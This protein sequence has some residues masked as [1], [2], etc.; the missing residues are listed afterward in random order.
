VPYNLQPGKKMEAKSARRA[1]ADLMIITNHLMLDFY[2]V[3]LR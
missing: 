1:P 3:A 2:S